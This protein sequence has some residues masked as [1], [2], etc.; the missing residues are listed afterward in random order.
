[1]IKGQG[2]PDDWN[3]ET[4]LVIARARAADGVVNNHRES[5]MKLGG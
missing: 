5:T 3:S 1:M 2:N 4:S